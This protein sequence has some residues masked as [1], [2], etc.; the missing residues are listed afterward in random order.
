MKRRQFL[1]LSSLTLAGLLAGCRPDRV[2]PT[3]YVPGST[4]P[5][6]TPTP[7]SV[8]QPTATLSP[9]V[10][11]IPLTPIKDLYIT[12]Y[13]VTP[14]PEQLAAWSLTIDG[15][16]DTPLTLTMDDIRAMPVVEAMRTLS[17]I[18]NPVGGALIGNIVWTGVDFATIL[19]K[20]S[21]SSQA[22]YVNFEAAD[23]YFTS[24]EL[25]W[26]TQ[27]GVM[28]VYLANGEPL[29]PDHGFPLRII[30]PGLYGQKQPKWITHITFSDTEKLG[31]WE[32]EFRGWSN[33][34][35]VQTLSQLREP[36]RD[37]PYA[38]QVRL[39]GM[40]FS[41]LEAITKVEIA[42]R[43][44]PKE[45]R[46]WQTVELIAPPSPLVWTWWTHIWTPLKPAL[47]R[48]AVRATDSSGFYQAR[49]ASG[50]FA[51]A[52]PDGSSSIQ[53]VL[54]KMD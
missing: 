28:L 38:S 54:F 36:S 10:T 34:A 6:P 9:S 7:T 39:V 5:P 53:E 21:V 15:L 3:V 2:V 4:R 25:K 18:S 24:V 14:K 8:P 40:A 30:I 11:E 47:Y 32:Q 19:E 29:P 37:I 51:G 12:S 46:V 16:V 43:T 13:R 31:Y 48:I 35:T 42:I 41:G 44:D 26:I 52:F 23:G 49:E 17:C 20:I 22:K 50:T 33:V 45:E 1:G 27:S